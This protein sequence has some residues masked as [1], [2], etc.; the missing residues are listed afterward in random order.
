MEG[1]IAV[2]QRM[3]SLG[4]HAPTHDRDAHIANASGKDK[5][6]Q[7]ERRSKPATM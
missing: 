5:L 4:S 7:V 2:G 3:C 1:S 6:N